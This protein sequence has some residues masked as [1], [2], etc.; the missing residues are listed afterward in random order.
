M[1]VQELI[2]KLGFQVDKQG[3]DTAEKGLSKIAKDAAKLYVAYQAASKAFGLV[4]DSVKG[5]ARLESMNAEFEVMLGNAEAA[6]YLVQQ[7]QQFAAVTPY[8]TAELTQNVR[9]MMAFGQSANESLSAVKMLGDVAGSDSEKLGRLSLAY[10]Q[11]MAAGKLQGQDLL[12]FVN[13]GFNP[14]QEISAKT[15]K[16]I[17]TLRAEME[18]G[19]ISSTMVS[20]AFASATGVGGRFFGNMEKQSQTLNGLW[21]TLTDNFQIMMAELGGQLVPFVKDVLVVLIDLGDEIAGAYRQLGDFFAL[22]FSDGPTAGDI[23]SGIAASFQTIADAI[24]AIGAGFQYVMVIADVFQG[25]FATVVGS[26]V[27][28]IMAIP[29]AFAYA[30]K[31][32]SMI[33]GAVA[34]LTGNRELA[35][36]NAQQRAELDQFTGTGGF[37]EYNQRAADNSMD[38]I[39][40]RWNKAGAIASM[41]GGS[42]AQDPGA[43]VSMTDSILKALEGRGKVVNN[44]VNVNNTIHAEG[45]MK[46]ILQE[47]ANSVFGLTFQQRLI[48]AAV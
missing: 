21:S 20:E 9:L 27:D 23:A 48:A 19:L 36:Y 44:T 24:M 38:A 3:L 2:A 34:K 43:K 42:K 39:G 22:M 13:A 47:Q 28:I 1:V 5:A 10:A 32:L 16:S 4:V 18:K 30:G 25:V 11:V 41:I 46:D 6:K 17:G 29:K 8:H 14:L 33:V 40:S 12:Q 35:A 26:L 45:S 37:L 15:G 31:G 7:I